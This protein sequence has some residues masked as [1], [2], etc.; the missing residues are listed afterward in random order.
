MQVKCPAE[1]TAFF[2]KNKISAVSNAF[3]IQDTNRK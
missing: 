2:R 1:E 3:P